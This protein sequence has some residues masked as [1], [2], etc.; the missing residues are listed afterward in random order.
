[1]FADWEL[2]KLGKEDIMLK[3]EVIEI[4]CCNLML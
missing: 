4:G 1:M 2:E 3:L